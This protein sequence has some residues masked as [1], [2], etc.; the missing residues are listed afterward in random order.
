MLRWSFAVSA[1]WRPVQFR[2]RHQ[3]E[4]IKGVF[5]ETDI[6][7]HVDQ[8]SAFLTHA[9]QSVEEKLGRKIVVQLKN[10]M[11]ITFVIWI[12]MSLLR[13]GAMIQMGQGVRRR[14]KKEGNQDNRKNHGLIG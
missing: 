12:F 2:H 5:A 11:N 7:L 1:V 9:I 6:L 3:F 10:I 4:P 8:S 14:K 13:M